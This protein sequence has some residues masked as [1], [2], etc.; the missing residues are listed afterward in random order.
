[1]KI[2]YLGDV[3]EHSTSAHRANAL[4]RLGH[5]VI[6]AHPRAQLPRSRLIGGLSVRLGFWIFSP[7]IL[8]AVK[9]AIGLKKFDLAWI[10]A[11]PEL[12]PSAY[13]LIRSLGMKVINYNVDDPFGNRD[14]RKWNLYRRS[15]SLQD[16]TVVVRDENVAEAK[17]VGARQVMRVYRSY[18]PVAH[19][20]LT[21]T[22]E[23]R[24]KWA[25][26]VAFIGTWMPERGPFMVRL[27]ELGVPLTIRGDWWQ[28]A[29][30]WDRLREVW[31]GPGIYGRDYVAATQVSKVSLGLLSKG[32]R[33]LHTQRTAEVPFIGG[34]AFCAEQTSEHERL[35]TH[36]QEAW[37]WKSP[38]ECAKYCEIV[39]E[40]ANRR[41]LMVR[42]A[43]ERIIAHQL[44]N[45]IIMQKI[46]I[47][48]NLKSV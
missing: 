41:A 29:P 4:R 32:N 7:L 40:D 36:G 17:A 6:H 5:E 35:F 8:R 44:S 26:E 25:S 12:G 21:L 1:M 24:R 45:D 10:D 28:K 27:I 34:A 31:R 42:K 15:V 13:R 9:N 20:P 2:L 23:D 3:F 39:L 19:H 18:D 33:D 11:G 47:G 46:L 43:H 38:E 14:G 16:L 48:L 22:P 37:L 30:E